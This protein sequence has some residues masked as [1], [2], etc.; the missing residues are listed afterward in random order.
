MM[1]FK[2][3]LIIISLI[4]ISEGL[5][6]LLCI[7]YGIYYHEPLKPFYIPA[8]ISITTGFLIF[9]ISKRNFQTITNN[10]EGIVL[11]IFSWLIL[12]L[13]GTLPDQ[14]SKTI[15]ASVD[16]FFE[17]ISGF[18]ATGSSILSNIEQLPKSILFWRSLT[19]WLG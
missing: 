19:N 16:V 17:T 8:I 13:V 2:N 11:I 3:L 12:I 10:R 4:L 15:P 18:T 14:V 9:S 5:S 1:L 7:P 6:F